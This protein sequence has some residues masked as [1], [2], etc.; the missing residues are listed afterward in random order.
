MTICYSRGQ[1]WSGQ[2]W[3]VA[4]RSLSEQEG[5]GAPC[6]ASSY[7]PGEGGEEEDPDTKPEQSCRRAGWEFQWPPTHLHFFLVILPITSYKSRNNLG[8][9][10]FESYQMTGSGAVSLSRKPPSS[11]GSLRGYHSQMPMVDSS[12]YLEKWMPQNLPV[13]SRR[14]NPS[15]LPLYFCCR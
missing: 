7:G 6:W 5:Q 2:L 1:A 4:T 14:E 8:K 3:A 10:T 11:R 15:G 12:T 9:A 13:S